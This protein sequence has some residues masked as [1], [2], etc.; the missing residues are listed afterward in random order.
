[1]SD[2]VERLK[3]ID[4]F[5]AGDHP[6]NWA[7]LGS[8]CNEA[9]AEIEKLRATVANLRQIAGAANIDGGPTFNQ[10]KRPSRAQAFEDSDT[11]GKFTEE[12]NG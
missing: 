10:I 1:M 4:T 7:D 3:V 8:L 5:L 12:S 2:I 6:P 9:V 11:L